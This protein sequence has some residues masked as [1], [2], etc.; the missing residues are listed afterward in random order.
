MGGISAIGGSLLL[1]VGTILHPSEADPNNSM[2]AFTE[3]TANQLWVVSHLTQFTGIALIVV[4]LLLLMHQMEQARGLAQMAKGGAIASLA[5]A[6]SLQAVDGVAL[7]VIVDSWAAA[8]AIQKED[9][10]Y[11]A[12]AVRQVEIGLAS[13][14]S[15]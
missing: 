10:F 1:F 12:F 6:A 8:P 9:L 7:K 3:Y 2:A 4:A 15:L 13:F 11:A 5:M 14:S